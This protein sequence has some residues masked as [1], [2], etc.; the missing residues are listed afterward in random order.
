[1]RA[2][3]NKLRALLLLAF[4]VSLPLASGCMSHEV[5]IQPITL[6]PIHMTLD[7]NLH[8]DHDGATAGAEAPP[9]PTP[10]PTPAS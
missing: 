10:A 1:M 8:V 5:R 7:V 6:E 4:A 3:V 2:I 9:S